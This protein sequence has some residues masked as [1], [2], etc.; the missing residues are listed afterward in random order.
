LPGLKFITREIAR[1]LN[2]ARLISAVQAYKPDIIYLRFGLFSFP[3]HALFKVA[4]VVI[5]INSN[6]LDEYRTKSLFFYWLNRITRGISFSHS[7]GM[8][9]FSYE[10]AALPANLKYRKPQCV[11][12]NGIDLNSLQPLPA[13]K[14]QSPVVVFVGTPGSP[15]HGVDK[16]YDL[17]AACPDLRIEVI[18]Y[19]TQEGVAAPANM[20]FH[21][22][23]NREEYAG[24]FAHADVA[25]GS[26]ALHRINMQ[27]GSPLKVRE[28]LGYGVPV[29]LSYND[30]DLKDLKADFLLSLPNTEDNVRLNIDRI[31]EFAYRMRGVRVDREL[32][33]PLIGQ[34]SKEEKRLAFF[35]KILDSSETRR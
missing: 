21:G 5:E 15:W 14:N 25:F 16:L 22:F 31:R 34:Y 35:K 6:D 28:A 32:I 2:L 26:L 24:I 33:R 23:L 3:L 1:S 13:P 9:V 4:P 19:Q 27:E 11:I 18:G 7:A 20:N 10:V 17:A 8:V 12:A 29:V 30:T